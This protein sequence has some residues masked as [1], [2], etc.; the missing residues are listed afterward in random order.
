MRDNDQWMAQFRPIDGV[1]PFGKAAAIPGAIAMAVPL[2][3]DSIGPAAADVIAQLRK[4]RGRP[5][6]AALRQAVAYAAELAPLVTALA[7]KLADGVYLTPGQSNLLFWGV[8]AL[9]A[10]RRTELCQPLL[11]MLRQADHDLLE[12]TFGDAINEALKHII[13]SVFDGDSDALIDAITDANVDGFIRWS[14][15]NA[16]ARLTFDGAL[17]RERTLDLLDRFE[18][19]PLAEPLDPA[20]EGWAEAVAYLGFEQLHDRLRQA[21]GDGRIDETM[22]ELSHWEREIATVRGMRPGD[23][24]LFDREGLTPVTDIVDVVNWIQTEAALAKEEEREQQADPAAKILRSYERAWLASFLS[25]EHVPGTTMSIEALDGYFA[26]LAIC[27]SETERADFRP[28]LWNYDAETEA[29]P[30]YDNDEQEEYVEG[31]LDRCLEAAKRRIASSVL[32][33]PNMLKWDDSELALNWA[34]G[35]L[36]GIALHGG[37]WGERCQADE[38]TAEFMSVIYA[39]TTGEFP[40]GDAFTAR[41]RKTFLAKLPTILGSLYRGWRGLAPLHRTLLGR[42]EPVVADPSVYDPH[43]S[44]P[45]GRKVGRNEPCPCGSGKKYKRCCGAT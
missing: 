44:R 26:A 28:A 7:E 14:L 13:I 8:H 32:H 25:S 37:L 18:R 23:P 5:D 40:N 16:L 2:L 33:P 20:W 30:H 36:R 6:D 34:A 19:V 42:A 3:Q 38:A 41:H 43:S 31:L 29:E 22:T 1:S 24:G 4:A 35:V 12:E 39:L 11:R 27:P 17:P 21:Y 15:L 10:A 45:F 9:G